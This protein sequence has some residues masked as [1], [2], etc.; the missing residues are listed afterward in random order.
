M[1]VDSSKSALKVAKI[2]AAAYQI[3]N[4]KFFT[5]DLF[6]N[7]PKEEKFNIIVSNP[8]YISAAEYKG[9][10]ISVKKQPRKALV[11]KNNGYYFYQEIFRQ[12]CFFSTKKFL[13]VIEIGHRQVETIIKLVINYFPRGKVSVFPDYSGNIRVMMLNGRAVAFQATDGEITIKDITVKIKFKEETT[14]DSVKYEKDSEHELKL[15]NVDKKELEHKSALPDGIKGK[16]K[17]TKA[18]NETE[19]PKEVEVEVKEVLLR[20]RKDLLVLE[21]DAEKFREL[22]QKPEFA[23]GGVV[24]LVEHR[25]SD[26]SAFETKIEKVPELSIKI[27]ECTGKP[28]TNVTELYKNKYENKIDI[29]LDFFVKE[30]NVKIGKT[31]R[32]VT[33]LLTDNVSKAG[34]EICKKEALLRHVRKNNVDK[35]PDGERKIDKN[36]NGVDGLKCVIKKYPASPDNSNEN[37][38]DVEIIASDGS[39]T[40][41]EKNIKLYA[42]FNLPQR[43]EYD[44]LKTFPSPQKEEKPF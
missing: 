5:S 39:V 43:T 2:N 3:K 37:R 38:I 23:C 17:L 33:Y 25:P 32:V 20:D 41:P 4:V 14:I 30:T 22:A 16:L 7:V 35:Q 42:Y 29:F 15:D 21:V 31:E 26:P 9:L 18:K 13:L 12:A 1:G 40:I 28:I 6:A 8:P 19:E 44:E 34:Y 11:A 36:E 24:Q 27:Y 10:A